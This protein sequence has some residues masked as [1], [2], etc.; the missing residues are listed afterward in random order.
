MGHSDLAGAPVN[1][2]LVFHKSHVPK[3]DGCLADTGDV[4]GGSFRVTFLLAYEV[5]NFGDRTGFVKG[6]I[7]V[8]DRD[9]S[10]E[11]L[12]VQIVQLDI[13]NIDEFA[14]GPG[15]HEGNYQ[16]QG[17]A[18]YHMDMLYACK[19]HRGCK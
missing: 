7:Y 6:S 11:A 17:I 12:G 8:I 15:V 18:A 14:C 13:I 16:Q 4:E 19:M 9:G 2:R 5:Y 3:D 1:L 10:R